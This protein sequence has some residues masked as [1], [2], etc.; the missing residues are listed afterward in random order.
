MFIAQHEAAGHMKIL[1][2]AVKVQ[3]NEEFT[4]AH[5]QKIM[6]YDLD[7]IINKFAPSSRTH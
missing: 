7:R 3:S 6:T 5:C 4:P 1:N 2:K